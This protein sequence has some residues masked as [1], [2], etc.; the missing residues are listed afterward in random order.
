MV[1]IEDV[2]TVL[3]GIDDPELPCSIVQLGLVESIGI[4]SGVAHIVLLPTFTGC[5]ALQMIEDDVRRTVAAMDGVDTCT[6]AWQYEPAWTPDRITS[7]GRER[8]HAHGV[9]TPAACC[10]A[11][12]GDATV[13]LTTSAVPCPY[14]GS[15][16]TRLDSPYGPTRCRQIHMCEDC[17]NQFEHMKPVS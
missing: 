14:C 2:R 13:S 11:A 15:A 10:G 4:E 5:P 7:A 16:N 8:L 3:D 17:R 6:V 9:T 12:G 1:S